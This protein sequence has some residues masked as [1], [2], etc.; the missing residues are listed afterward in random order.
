MPPVSGRMKLV[1]SEIAT[2]GFPP[3][4]F[5]TKMIVPAPEVAA[6][7]AVAT[8]NVGSLISPTKPAVAVTGPE[9]V[10]DAIIYT[11]CT[12]FCLAVCATSGRGVSCLQG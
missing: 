1:P 9:N 3:A 2:Q 8:V 4:P 11:L 5:E 6:D 7:G 12:R 10:V